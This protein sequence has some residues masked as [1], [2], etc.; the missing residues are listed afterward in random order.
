MSEWKECKLGEVAEI[1]TGPFG[2]LLHQ[3]DYKVVGTPIIT[4]EHLGENRVLHQNLPLVGDA[5]KER[6]KRYII[7]EGDIVFSRVGS[8]DRRAYV[9]KRE[10]GWMFSGRL[11]R[12]RP[13]RKLVSSMYL[14]YY[15]GQED[16]KEHIRRIAVGA[17]MPSI[18]TSILSGVDI[19]L[20]PLP[21][22]RDIA[23][24]LSSLDDK[25]DLLHRQNK[26]LE[27]M[28][29]TL[30]RKW[31]VVG[32]DEGWD[33][34]RVGD[35]VHTNVASI[36]RN[37]TLKT[38]RYLDTGSLTEGKIDGYQTFDIAD[39][40]SRARRIVKHNDVLI[41]TVRPNQKHYGILKNPTEDVIVSTGFC[42]ITCDK[43]N[44][45]F[46]YIL[47]T[48]DEMTEYLHSIA[49]G[50]TSTY[51]SLKP[52]DI[53]GLVFQLPPQE[54]L[55]AFSEY[56]DNAW[57]KIEYNHTQIRTLEKLRDTLLPKLMGGEVRLKI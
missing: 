14:S 44:P 24:V 39:A 2:S 17:T 23:S 20:P 22:Q 52:S 7:Y 18:N 57:S 13:D 25:I 38:I 50:S 42:V 33:S 34:V 37:N 36:N 30:F 53:E 40:P 46:I 41:S 19:L 6:L 4:V 3:R 11:L 26:T 54:K 28:A 55:D 35:F 56:A 43:I 1:Q 21:E 12:V 32:A 48:T 9:S 15:F 47:L 10:N 16:F 45:H 51:P 8:V 49:E 5:D 29:E 31:F 27:A